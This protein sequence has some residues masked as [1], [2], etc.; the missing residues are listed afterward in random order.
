MERVSSR[1]RVIVDI[2]QPVVRQLGGR[3]VSRHR[4]VNVHFVHPQQRQPAVKGRSSDVKH[5]VVIVL[6]VN[7]E[8][9]VG[10]GLPSSLLHLETLQGDVHARVAR[11]VLDDKNLRSRALIGRGDNERKLVPD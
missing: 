1:R 3:E 6:G 9:L 11:F 4:P 2:N 10:D 5:K 8:V 7:V